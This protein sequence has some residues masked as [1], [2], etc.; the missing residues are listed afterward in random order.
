MAPALAA[1]GREGNRADDSPA[2]VR[3]V[4]YLP[5]SGFGPLGAGLDLLV[6]PVQGTGYE[7][8]GGGGRCCPTGPRPQP[9]G[10]GEH[11][12]QAPPDRPRQAL[13]RGGDDLNPGCHGA[14][15]REAGEHRRAAGQSGG[16][17]LA[18]HRGQGRSRTDGE[19]PG[20]HRPGAPIPAGHQRPEG[21]DRQRRTSPEGQLIGRGAPDG[22][23]HR[24]LGALL[25][26]VLH[27]DA[28]AQSRGVGSHLHAPGPGVRAGARSQP[29]RP[30]RSRGLPEGDRSQGRGCRQPGDHALL[31][32]GARHQ[33]RLEP[34]RGDQ[35]GGQC[36][37]TCR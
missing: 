20:N 34:D 35:A 11:G 6:H 27:H 22:P 10:T 4:G 31:D 14:S 30:G 13:L 36:P 29:P 5:Q 19:H 23:A 21:A 33:A 7:R 25:Q 9:R 24:L 8:C 18:H 37:G 2:D 16:G 15:G 12:G 28:P 17:T 26:Q 32:R 1:Q 3:V